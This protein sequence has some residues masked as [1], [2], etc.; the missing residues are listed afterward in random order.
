MGIGCCGVLVVL[1]SISSVVTLLHLVLLSEFS[2]MFVC[3]LG[4]LA[5]VILAMNCGHMFG[6]SDVSIRDMRRCVRI[7][8]VLVCCV[9][10]SG[11]GESGG[12]GVVIGVGLGDFHQVFVL[13]VCCFSFTGVVSFV[14]SWFVGIW[15][16]LFHDS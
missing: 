3:M 8:H 7:F 6:K 1:C 4:L 15:C 12:C 9:V 2:A 14:C 5:G 13:G 16:V 11:V 10:G